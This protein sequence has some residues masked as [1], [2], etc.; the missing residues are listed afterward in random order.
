MLLLVSTLREFMIPCIMQW[1]ICQFICSS[2]A[3]EE[4][5]MFQT[6]FHWS[7]YFFLLHCQSHTLFSS[8]IGIG[9]LDLWSYFISAWFTTCRILAMTTFCLQELHLGCGRKTC[10]KVLTFFSAGRIMVLLFCT[11]SWICR[12]TWCKMG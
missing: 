10:V 9:G 8:F 5:C 6:I 12:L 3:K 11:G 7:L 2:L 4:F 1:F